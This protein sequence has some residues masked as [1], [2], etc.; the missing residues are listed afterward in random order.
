MIAPTVDPQTRSALV[1]VDLT[2]LPQAGAGSAAGL[3]Q[4][5]KAS[6]GG[7]AATGFPASGGAAMPGM[8]ARGEFELGSTPALVVPQPAVVV[9]DGFSYVYRVNAD[10]RVSQIKVQ[11]GRFDNGR[12]EVTGGLPADARIV[13]A[14]AGFLNDG[15]LVRIVDS[16]TKQPAARANSTADATK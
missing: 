7:S 4:G 10:S 14:G 6:S 12:V 9:R 1:Y 16:E 3:V 15:D 11:T 13:A 8:F 2:S 5:A